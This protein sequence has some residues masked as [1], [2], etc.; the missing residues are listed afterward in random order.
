MTDEEE[1]IE[2]IEE[3]DSRTQELHQMIENIDYELGTLSDKREHLVSQL[4]I[5][6]RKEA[7]GY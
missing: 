1:L 7:L 5:L 6:E 2:E 3:I 4:K